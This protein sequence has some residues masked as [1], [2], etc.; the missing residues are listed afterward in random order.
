M[1]FSEYSYV[2]FLNTASRD[3]CISRNFCLYFCI[4]LGLKYNLSVIRTVQQF[5]LRL[6]IIQVSFFQV[7]GLFLI[8][9]SVFTPP[10]F[11]RE[12]TRGPYRVIRTFREP[13]RKLHFGYGP[14]VTDP[15]KWEPIRKLNF[16][17]G[18]GVTDPK[19][20]K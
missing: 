10:L 12:K 18:P 13:I 9:K 20:N 11:W 15:K 14:G 16:G 5:N 3:V 19:K 6:L 4:L 8:L 7:F 1:N 17:Y 2:Y